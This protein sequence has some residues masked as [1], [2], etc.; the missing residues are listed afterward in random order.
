MSRVREAIMI[1]RPVDEVFA[2]VVDQRNEVRY[3]PAMASVAMETEPPIS[4]GSR[5]RATVVMRGRPTEAVIEYTGVDPPHR[6]TSCS[7]TA[8]TVMEGSIRCDPKD[9][10]TLFS[11]DWRVTL[12]GLLRLAGPLVGLLGAHQERRIWTG[13]KHHLEESAR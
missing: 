7:V 10:G 8:G 1:D 3:N 13:L 2:T 12:P 9:G 5:F 4:V 11:W 6:L